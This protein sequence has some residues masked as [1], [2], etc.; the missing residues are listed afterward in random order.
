MEN[1]ESRMQAFEESA[2]FNK[3]DIEKNVK[4][5]AEFKGQIDKDWNEWLFFKN[6]GQRPPCE[7]AK[8]YINWFASRWNCCTVS[9]SSSDWQKVAILGMILV[10]LLAQFI[11]LPTTRVLQVFTQYM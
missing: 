11:I 5:A 1:I 3:L 9:S 6:L 7:K 8:A 10:A 4:K 2:V